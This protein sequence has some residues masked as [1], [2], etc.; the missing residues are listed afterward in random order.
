M[1]FARREGRAAQPGEEDPGSL[2]FDCDLITAG[3]CNYGVSGRI[4]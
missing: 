3:D 4:L 2:C 1:S